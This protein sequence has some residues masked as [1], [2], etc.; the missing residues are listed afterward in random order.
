MT[1]CS[2]NT[3][4]HNWEDILTKNIEL[5]GHR[6]WIVVADS[7]YPQQSNPGITT[8]VSDDDHITTIK[9]VNSLITKQSHITPT[10][11]LDSEIDFVAEVDSPGISV[12]RD[13]LSN[14]LIGNTSQKMVHDDIISKLDKASDLFNVIIIKT[15]FTIPYTTVFYYLDCKYWNNSAE[16]RLRKS[17][18]KSDILDK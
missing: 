8:I 7:A 1:L 4:K 14:I 2:C 18:L 9:K 15:D 11:Y 3:A 6:N 5:M 16:Q 10:I 13:S 17:M 12:F